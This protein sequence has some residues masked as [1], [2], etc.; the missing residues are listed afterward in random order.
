MS[1]FRWGVPKVDLFANRSN[2]KC[3]KYFFFP[4]DPVATA[5]DAL[6][7]NWSDI[8]AFAFPPF[9]PVG[10][11]I[12]KAVRKKAKLILVCPRWPSQPWWPLVQ[13]YS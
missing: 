5:V 13:Q 9:S 11:V 7:Q 4:P 8:S 6:K 1:L 12:A 3:Q 10:M 2:S